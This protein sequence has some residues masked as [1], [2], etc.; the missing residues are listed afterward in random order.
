MLTAKSTPFQLAASLDATNLQADD[1]VRPHFG[2]HFMAKLF[3]MSLFLFTTVAFV[4]LSSASV[5]QDSQFKTVTFPSVDGLEITADLYVKHAESAPFIVL[6][7]QAGWS[8]GEYREIA[9]KLNELGFNCMAIDQRSGKAVNGIDNETMKRAAADS[10]GTQ[11][12]DA[13]Q[14][15]VAALKYAKEKYAKGKLLLWGSSYSAALT[16]RVAG[17]N[18]DLIDGALAF[19]PGEYF[20]R[21]NKPK[22]FIQSSAKKIKKPIFV[23]SAKNEYGN[24]KAIFDAVSADDKTKFL[25]ETRGQ[26]GSRALWTKFSD[27]DAY[28]EATKAF[29]KQFT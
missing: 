24:W 3:S 22:D 23:T 19:A 27:N 7:H 14:D 25:P 10:K 26:H 5:G 13:E 16:L 4:S 18:G 1:D 28:W 20:V 8:R 11:F 6:C 21:F 17:E 29:L 9:P 15:M 12:L 2:D